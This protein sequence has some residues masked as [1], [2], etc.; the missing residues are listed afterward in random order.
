[1]QIQKVLIVESPVHLYRLIRSKEEAIDLAS[2]E[3]YHL[4]VSFLD[5]VDLFL[6]GCKCD[7]DSNFSEMM[8]SYGRI[9]NYPQDNLKRAFECDRIEFK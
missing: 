9:R 1:M 2:D 4:I 7:E 5:S 3:E 6:N 8:D